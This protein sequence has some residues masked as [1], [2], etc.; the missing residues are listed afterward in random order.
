MLRY[1]EWLSALP[2]SQRVEI[3]SAPA[4]ERVEIVK[5]RLDEQEKQRRDF[6]AMQFINQQDSFEIRNWM[7][8]IFKR[9]EPDLSAQ[10]PPDRRAEYDGLDEGR[11]FGFVVGAVIRKQRLENNPLMLDEIMKITEEDRKT[12]IQKLSSSARDAY[13][14]AAN[15]NDRRQ[16]LLSWMR[17]AVFREIMRVSPQE[18]K[19]FADRPNGKVPDHL[20]DQIDYLSQHQFKAEFEGFI[21]EE[22]RKRFGD[23]PPGFPRGPFKGGPPHPP[24]MRDEREKS[25][26]G[27]E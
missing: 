19:R 10:L 1:H 3:M 26:K 15:E 18:V 12:L 5:K 17:T 27:R 4:S 8:A 11:R 6:L 23:G 20:R 2:S 21:R 22:S 14:S 13:Q 16:L 9:A 7:R 25:G 24:P